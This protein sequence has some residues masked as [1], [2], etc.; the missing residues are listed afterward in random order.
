M[1]T[2]EEA[3]DKIGFGLFQALLSLFCG[4]IMVGSYLIV[5]KYVYVLHYV[6]LIDS[7]ASMYVLNYTRVCHTHTRTQLDQA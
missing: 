4:A 3:V 1:Y 2:V 7:I 6:L 5:L